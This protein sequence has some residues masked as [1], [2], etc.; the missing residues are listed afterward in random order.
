MT[1]SLHPRTYADPAHP[2][3]T[4][5]IRALEVVDPNKDTVVLFYTDAP[6]HHPIFRGPNNKTERAAFPAGETDWVKLANSAYDKHMRIFSFISAHRNETLSFYGY[7]S[8]ATGGLCM[9][10]REETQRISRLTIDTLLTWMGAVEP[11]ATPFAHTGEAITYAVSP[12]D[13]PKK[14][15]DEDA[16][17]EGYLPKSN[18]KRDPDLKRV[19]LDIL[20]DL[21]RATELDSKVVS[22]PKRFA[23]QTEVAYRALVYSTLNRIIRHNVA[24]LTYN[25][26]FGQLWRAVCR[27]QTEEKEE[28]VQAFGKA[29]GDI[30]NA[31]QRKSMTDW[32]EQSYDSSVEVE[33]IV[34]SATE[35]CQ[36]MYLDLDAQVDMT[37]VELLEA[38]RS[39]HRGVL[40]KLASIFTHVKVCFAFHPGRDLH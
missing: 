35:G 2:A 7:L 29:V 13:A 12:L 38:S 1:L 22:L 11:S 37:R 17:N 4:A 27:E 26:V 18:G 21:P 30:K 9:T 23:D 31:D 36:W 39:F 34:K 33:E 5:L 6:P 3:K 20:R 16:G 19:P 10:V 8:Q 14:P 28:I 15:T 24:S 40:K 32:L 25:A